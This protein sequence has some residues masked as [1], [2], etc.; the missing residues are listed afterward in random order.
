MSKLQ[1]PELW[2]FINSH[3]EREPSRQTHMWFGKP[4]KIMFRVEDNEYEYFINL[5]ATTIENYLKKTKSEALHL[6]ELPLEIGVLCFDLDIKFSDDKSHKM[7][8]EPTDII[9]KINKI[10]S[11][12]FILTDAKT[13][14]I[15]YY[16][17]KE[18]PFHNKEKEYYS[19]GIHITYPNIVLDSQ[20][21]DFIMDLLIEEIIKDGDFNLLMEKL[22]IEKLN[23]NKISFKLDEDIFRNK[24]NTAMDI[25]I[26]KKTKANDNTMAIMV[27]E[28]VISGVKI[29]FTVSLPEMIKVINMSKANRTSFFIRISLKYYYIMS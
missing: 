6:L 18:T 15:S 8:I 19:D 11:R 29:S 2:N 10:I 13:Q 5:V 25:S 24:D 4:E 26:Y 3:I 22:L 12:Y 23:K 16:F 21:K 7:F 1:N 27:N 17:V 20:N 14:L 9:E 28:V